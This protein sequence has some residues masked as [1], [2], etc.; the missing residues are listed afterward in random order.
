MKSIANDL[1]CPQTGWADEITDPAHQRRLRE[2]YYQRYRT[3]PDPASHP[4][5]FDPV[6]PPDGWRYDLAYEMWIKEVW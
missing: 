1:D 3:S 6:D 5:L 2:R 4:E